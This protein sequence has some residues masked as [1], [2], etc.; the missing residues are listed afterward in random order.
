MPTVPAE[1]RPT[2][3]KAARAAGAIGIPGAFSAGL[4]VAAISGI[5][6]RMTIGIAQK[7]G[8]DVDK[9]LATKL[10][11]AVASGMAGYVGASRLATMLLHGIPGAGTIAAV[12]INSAMNFFYTWRFG[13]GLAAMFDKPGFTLGDATTMARQ[14]VTAIAPLPSRSELLEVLGAFRTPVAS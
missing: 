3:R 9:V 8:H 6:I 12:G 4:D 1:H 14:L 7:S 11:A 5:W 13:A 2:V 10:V